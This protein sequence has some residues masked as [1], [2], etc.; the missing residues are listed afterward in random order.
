MSADDLQDKV[1]SI[2]SKV[3][4]SKE[5]DINKEI[6]L[7]SLQILKTLSYIERTFKIEIDDDLVFSGLFSVPMKL[8]R[9]LFQQL[10]IPP[11]AANNI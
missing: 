8:I 3:T 2:Y 4:N 11:D 9:Y 7:S 1:I 6:E 5:I 10:D